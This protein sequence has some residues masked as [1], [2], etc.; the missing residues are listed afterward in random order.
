MRRLS[1]LF[2]LRFRE[3]ER[4]LVKGEFERSENEDG[5]AF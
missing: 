4:C 5:F 3:G 2:G 1:C